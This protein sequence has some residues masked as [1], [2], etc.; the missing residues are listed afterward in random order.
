MT[1]VDRPTAAAEAQPCEGCPVATSRRTFLRDAALA[2]AAAIAAV[3]IGKP[4]AAFA[5]TV[6]EIGPTS[7][8]NAR[9]PERAYAIPPADSVSV[10]VGN[11]VMLA[12]WQNRV[13]AFSLTCPHKGAQL[14]WRIAEQRVYCPKHKA[15][16][17]SDGSHVSGRGSRDLD[18]YGIRRGAEGI[19]VDLRRAYRADTD[20]AAWSRAVVSL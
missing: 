10:D 19:V 6:S 11:D 8:S 4:A 15:R 18:R 1:T 20:N 7:A 16:F 2:A 5:E 9:L 12:R 3:S 14:E 17:L 13:Y